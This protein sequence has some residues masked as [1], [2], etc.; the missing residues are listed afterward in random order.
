MLLRRLPRGYGG[1]IPRRMV[2]RSILSG[3]EGEFPRR[4]VPRSISGGK[5]GE[6][7][8]R[9]QQFPI[10]RGKRYSIP[11]QNGAT[12]HS[13]RIW[14]PIPA[15]NGATEHPGRKRGRFPAQ[16]VTIFSSQAGKIP[17]SRAE[18]CNRA[19]R[20]ERGGDFPHRTV[21]PGITGG[22][23]GDFPRRRQQFPGGSGN[24]NN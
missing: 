20:A 5:G 8:R 3:K 2:P 6:F 18:G 11:A 22:K 1:R 15:Q 4:T 17:N 10:W 23:G 21:L 16:A 7:W 14:Q 13:A 9:R 19:L 24:I 12:E